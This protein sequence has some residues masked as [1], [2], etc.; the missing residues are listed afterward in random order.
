[1]MIDKTILEVFCYKEEFDKAKWI[2]QKALN[3]SN[4]KV[5]SNLK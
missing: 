3:K 1:M 5:N 2:Y 4:F